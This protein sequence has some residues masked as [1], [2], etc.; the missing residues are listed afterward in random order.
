MRCFYRG[1]WQKAVV[2]L[3]VALQVSFASSCGNVATR[4]QVVEAIA[5]ENEQGHHISSVPFVYQKDKHCGPAALAS[6]LHYYGDLVREEVVAKEVFCPGLEGSL[7]SDLENF[8]RRRGFYARV[9]RGNLADL[10]LHIERNEPVIIL[11]EK[12]FA[13]YQQ[14]HYVV[15]VGY[16]D[17]RKLVVLQTGTE[18]DAL[19]SYDRL[20]S[21][22][23]RMNHLCLLVLPISRTPK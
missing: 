4:R 8:A 12:G 22:W 23:A 15:V 9:Y 13:V 7:I 17:G 5:I 11:V 20:E 19:W 18:P 6:V 14:P 10:K 2:L 1:A 21:A 3:A 16:D